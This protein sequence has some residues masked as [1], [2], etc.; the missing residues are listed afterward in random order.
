MNENLI[1]FLALGSF[2]SDLCRCGWIA[3]WVEITR[4]CRTLRGID[5][6]NVS[7]HSK[8]MIALIHVIMKRTTNN[9]YG[10]AILCIAHH[11]VLVIV[12]WFKQN[13]TLTIMNCA[14]LICILAKIMWKQCKAEYFNTLSFHD[15]HFWLHALFS[16]CRWY[17]KYG[18]K[19]IWEKREGF[20]KVWHGIRG[21]P[22]RV[23]SVII[24]FC[25][26]II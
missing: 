13:L 20:V 22:W 21:K 7:I 25:N 24:A 6:W 12:L 19:W 8:F 14:R 11:I 5:V 10:F 16:F 17:G 1:Y 3:A 9:Y 18:H 23:K 26:L 4:P 15:K 2:C